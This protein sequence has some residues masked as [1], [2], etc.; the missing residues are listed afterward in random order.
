MLLLNPTKKFNRFLTEE[1]YPHALNLAKTQFKENPNRGR[2]H[3]SFGIDRYRIVAVGINGQKTHP[4]MLELG[5]QGM[6]MHS[7]VDL[8]RQLKTTQGITLLNMRLSKTGVFGM[9]KPC[10]YCMAW[11]S[12]AFS[13]ILYT[14]PQGDLVELV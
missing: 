11:C 8:V 3:L 12:A 1:I 6:L 7:E 13:R 5:Y 14:D 2:V 4:K 10:A 9:S